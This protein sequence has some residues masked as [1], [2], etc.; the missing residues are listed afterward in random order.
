METLLAGIRAERV[1]TSRQ[2]ERFR[3]ELRDHLAR[4]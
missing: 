3:T 4:A 2:A 1:A